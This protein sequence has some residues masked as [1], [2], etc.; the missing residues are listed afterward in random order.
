[1]HPLDPGTVLSPDYV[2]LHTEDDEQHGTAP[3]GTPNAYN[4]PSV[5]NHREYFLQYHPANNGMPL[6]R[7]EAV[8]YEPAASN[9]LD[10]SPSV[11]NAG[12]GVQGQQSTGLVQTA[13]QP[14]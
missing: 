2:E 8:R 7:A 9:G 1:M 11:T 6:A 14:A 13:P 12:S 3:K 10:A 5:P 4:D